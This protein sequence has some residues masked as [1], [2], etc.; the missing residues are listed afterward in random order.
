MPTMFDCPDMRKTLRGFVW[1][2]GFADGLGNVSGISTAI[3]GKLHTAT[4]TSNYSDKVVHS[5]V[6]YTQNFTGPYALH[7]AYWHDE[8]GVPKSGGCVNLSPIDGMRLFQWTE[9]RLPQDWHAM[10]GI[11][12]DAEHYR[13][14][15]VVSLHE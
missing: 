7:V 4:M 3:T 1:S 15:T 9:P 11:E 6:P 2:G 13:A 10:R 5:E 8:W 14:A 12:A